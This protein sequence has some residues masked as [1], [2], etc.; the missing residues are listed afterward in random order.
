MKNIICVSGG[1]DS[2]ALALHCKYELKLENI[3]YIYND[4]KWEAE[5]SVVNFYEHLEYLNQNVF[6]GKLH[7][8]DSEGMIPLIHRKKR[9][10]STMAKFCT[11]ELKI[12]PLINW[13]KTIEDDYEIWLGKR[14]AESSKR[15]NTKQKEYSDFYDC[16]V[17][18]PLA[19]WTWQDVFDIH[20][21][22]NIEPNPLYK[23][24]FKRVGCMPCINSGMKDVRLMVQYMPEEIDKIR[25]AENET[26]SSWFPPGFIPDWACSREAKNKD[27]ILCKFPTIDDVVKYVTNN[28][29]QLHLF[30][31]QPPSCMSVYG[32]C[33]NSEK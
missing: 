30:D 31:V 18:N 11:E 4:T 10:P 19:D 17:N 29:D 21:K 3:V 6:D 5:N 12:K 8:I 20:K 33:D 2:T 32:L 16:Y 13:L 1:K 9:T 7:I 24:G 26:G 27:G 23:L 28:P 22:Y 25:M 14:K 15:A